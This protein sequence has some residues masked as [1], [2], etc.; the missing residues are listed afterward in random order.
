MNP[1]RDRMIEI[2][3][4]PPYRDPMDYSKVR[5]SLGD[6]CPRKGCGMP[7][8]RTTLEHLI[9]WRCY[10]DG[11]EVREHTSCARLEFNVIANIRPRGKFGREA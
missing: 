7:L 9:I 11:Y 1:E 4:T 2:S 5:P 3:P 10:A 8:M 6:C